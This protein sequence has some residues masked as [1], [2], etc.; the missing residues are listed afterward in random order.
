[1]PEF[2]DI[3]VYCEALRERV[4]GIPISRVRILNPFVLRTVEPPIANVGGLKVSGVERLGKRIVLALEGELFL[5]IHLMISG[6]LL[7]FDSIG[8]TVKTGGKL[9]LARV[10]FEHGTLVL[11]EASSKKRA[12][13]H[14]VAGRQALLSMNPGGLE[15]LECT[16]DELK[17]RLC[18]TNRTLKRALTSPQ[19][20]SGVGNAY[21]DEILHAAGISPVR[22]TQALKPEEWAKLH[23]A[24]QRTLTTWH[25]R[26]NLERKGKF[27]GRGQVTA[28][29]PDFAAHG[30]FGL[31]C[32]TCQ[33]P[34]QRIQYAE[35]ET[36]YCAR[37]QNEDRILAD[38]S[39][40]RLLK[41]DW[42]R[43]LE[44]LVGD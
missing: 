10:E 15:P 11:T 9:F 18:L 16:P 24:M 41:E 25:E 34:I 12:S 31:P 14:L 43:T 38:R 7:W 44:E 13:I 20:L 35:N 28:F 3:E 30:K 5:V 1:M 33:M 42:P 2:P 36:N 23:E 32:P 27:P 39:L 4:L 21:S 26:L 17:T 22:L 19:L 37:C 40:S 6:R 8:T 29:R